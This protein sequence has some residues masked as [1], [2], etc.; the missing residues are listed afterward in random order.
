MY[1]L[2]TA[3]PRPMW[4]CEV[5]TSLYLRATFYSSLP[6]ITLQ[7]NKLSLHHVHSLPINDVKS[8][9]NKRLGKVGLKDTFISIL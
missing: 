6:L 7:V 2:K 3:L 9:L 1:I 4:S 8:I 5:E